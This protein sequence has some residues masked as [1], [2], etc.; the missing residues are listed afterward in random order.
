MSVRSRRASIL[1]SESS[2][3]TSARVFLVV[4][5]TVA[6]W[7]CVCKAGDMSAVEVKYNESTFGTPTESDDQTGTNFKTLSDSSG[8][9][10]VTAK[11]AASSTTLNAIAYANNTG[12]GT[13]VS[14]QSGG[15]YAHANALWVDNLTVRY[16]SAPV[17]HVRAVVKYT[18]QLAESDNADG[19]YYFVT[20]QETLGVRIEC[21]SGPTSMLAVSQA[22]PGTYQELL[23]VAGDPQDGVA[24]LSVSA[25]LSAFIASAYGY[26]DFSSAI[27]DS[28]FTPPHSSV[29][30]ELTAADDPSSLGVS[31]L[32]IEA[33]DADGNVLPPDLVTV[34][35]SSGATY[36]VLP[37]PGALP[38]VLLAGGLIL[39]RGRRAAGKW[40][41][42]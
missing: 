14:G 12:L 10:T 38:A 28:S 17:P 35:S 27:L 33:L 36:T 24:K 30:S 7:G 13:T 8:T 34:S 1:R 5:A 16:N 25:T 42:V 22:T 29:A 4:A 41:T 6:A 21:G 19:Q 18:G 32:G 2:A 31:I 3:L 39:I 15:A 26:S 20:A 11:A 37:E 23:Q 9:Q 40:L